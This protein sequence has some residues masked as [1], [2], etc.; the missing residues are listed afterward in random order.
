MSSFK[1]IRLL[2]LDK[3]IVKVY[4][5][6]G[7]GHVTNIRFFNTSKFQFST[8]CQNISC[9]F[10]SQIGKTTGAWSLILISLLNPKT[11]NL[12][13]PLLNDIVIFWFW[14]YS[15]T[16]SSCGITN[17]NNLSWNKEAGWR[18]HTLVNVNTPVVATTSWWLQ[19]SAQVVALKVKKIYSCWH[20][21]LFINLHLFYL[22][23]HLAH[24]QSVKLQ[25]MALPSNWWF[26]SWFGLQIQQSSGVLPWQ[27]LF[28]S[29]NA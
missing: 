8:N 21:D 28:S 27:V 6:Y 16:S 14:G 22:W 17:S 3:K 12:I 26:N 11:E 25:F 18:L 13:M 1:I 20:Y 19:F 7:I 15:R 29:V 9:I 24:R 23:W 4:T 5:I 10:L 2:V